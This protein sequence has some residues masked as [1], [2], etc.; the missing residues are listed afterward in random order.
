MSRLRGFGR[1][2]M[3]GTNFVPLN[4]YFDTEKIK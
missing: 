4:V 2:E 1:F 3:P